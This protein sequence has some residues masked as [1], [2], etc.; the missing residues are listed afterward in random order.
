VV[1][2]TRHYTVFLSEDSSDDEFLQEED[3]VSAFSEN[4]IFSA[5]FEWPQQYRTLKESSDGDEMISP[6]KEGDS[7]TEQ[8][9]PNKDIN[10]L[11]DI[12]SNIDLPSQPPL[13]NQAKSLE[14]LRTPKEDHEDQFT[15]DYQ[16]MDFSI[17]ERNR[18]MPTIKHSHPY[19]KLWGLGQDDM[20]IPNKYIQTSP[21]RYQTFPRSDTNTPQRELLSIE[22]DAPS[23]S[24]QSSI[25]IPRPQGRKTPELGIVPPPPAPR[26]SKQQNASTS[27]EPG[28]QLGDSTGFPLQTAIGPFAEVLAADSNRQVPD[29][30]SVDLLQPVKV[31]TDVYLNDDILSLLDP[32]KTGQRHSEGLSAVAGNIQ[33]TEASHSS[34]TPC[35][36]PLQ[37]DFA[38]TVFPHQLGFSTPRPPFV[39]SPLNPF[40]QVMPPDQSVSII[41]I[42]ARPFTPPVVSNPLFTRSVFYH[43]QRRPVPGFSRSSLLSQVPSSS[44]ANP[45]MHQSHATLEPTQNVPS[46]I[47]GPGGQRTFH[48]T[49]PQDGKPREYPVI[50]PRPSKLSDPVLLPSKPGQPNDPFEELL[51]KTK[52]AV[53]PTPGKVEQ[54]RKRWETFE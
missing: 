31:A 53:T 14:D 44:P 43:S 35:F 40:I 42:A 17:P 3:P 18:L 12:F 19:N 16:R 8:E 51:S 37:S 33:S 49:Q 1:K 4:F 41:G 25:T 22:Q 32:L 52:Q 5:P 46:V 26:L 24:N 11:E 29:S 20:A 21:E 48:M 15:F 28:K 54:L 27:T 23:S 13:L 6:E 9:Q 10:L 45:I 36:A 2:P 30:S 47:S 34:S 38:S 7:F 39:H 50:P